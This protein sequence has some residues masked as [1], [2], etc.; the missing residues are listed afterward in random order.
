MAYLLNQ[1]ACLCN[2]IY[3]KVKI[4]TFIC[5]PIVFESNGYKLIT[6]DLWRFLFKH[7]MWRET[8]ENLSI[9]IFKCFGQVSQLWTVSIK[10]LTH[11]HITHTEA[12]CNRLTPKGVQE[13][14]DSVFVLSTTDKIFNIIQWIQLGNYFLEKL[15]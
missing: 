8:S 3:G 7:F 14:W 15:S 5:D 13:V 2:F 11:T 6:I 1:N 4:I 10:G 9:K 12:A